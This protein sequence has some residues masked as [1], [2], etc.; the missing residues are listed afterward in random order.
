M[1]L[2]SFISAMHVLCC[3]LVWRMVT[4]TSCSSLTTSVSMIKPST[5]TSP[6]EVTTALEAP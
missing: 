5:M 3:T 4:R 1:S 6:T 2:D